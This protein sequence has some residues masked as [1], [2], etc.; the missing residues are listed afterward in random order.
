MGLA[1]PLGCQV[2]AWECVRGESVCAVLFLWVCPK[3]A[4]AEALWKQNLSCQSLICFIIVGEGK[5][6]AKSVCVCARARG[7]IIA[8][9][10][11]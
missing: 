11:S 10:R 2:C 5:E 6:E 3:Q 7:S 8:P 1:Q 9:A 4:S